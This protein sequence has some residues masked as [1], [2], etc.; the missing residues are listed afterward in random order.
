MGPPVPLKPAFLSAVVEPWL[1]TLLDERARFVG[2]P[3]RAFDV[4]VAEGVGAAPAHKLR[5]ALRALARCEQRPPSSKHGPALRRAVFCS[6]SEGHGR[7]AVMEAVARARGITILELEAQLFADL[8]SER[9]LGPLTAP[10]SAA[11]LAARSNVE[12]LTQILARALLV[13]IEAYGEVRAV[14]RHAK[15]LGLLCDLVPSGKGPLAVLEISGPF[16]LF[17]H[18]RLYARAL[19]SLVPRLAH[20]GTYRLEADC[21]LSGGAR[22]GRVTVRA[23]DPVLPARELPRFDSA[24]EERFASDFGLLAPDWELVREPTPLRAGRQLV[25][26]D[27]GLR[28]RATGELFLLEI[29]GYWTPS[30]LERKLAA[31]REVHCDKLVLCIDVTKACDSHALPDGAAIIPFRRRLDARAVLARIDPLAAERL[32]V[33][34]AE[35]ARRAGRGRAR[36]KGARGGCSRR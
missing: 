6:S 28:H 10:L 1:R 31:L 22:L 7:S 21:V 24:L 12:V 29:V 30:Y 19:A 2:R 16:A 33:R 15:L 32:A 13:R 14:V 27:F 17:Q 20:C 25:F 35:G 8:E 36:G 23:G 26:P 9:A 5:S 34:E 4:R 18:S 3:A 11:E